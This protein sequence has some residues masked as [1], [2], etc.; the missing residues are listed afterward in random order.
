M[1]SELWDGEW[2]TEA[3]EVL[4]FDLA[5][6]CRDGPAEELQKTE[7]AQPALF[8]A[9]Y[10]AWAGSGLDAPA[11]VAG[12]S[13]GEYT[14]VAA[15]GALTFADALRLVAER[16]RAMAAAG[17]ENP[18]AMAALLGASLEEAAALCAQLEALWVAAC[19]D[20]A[21]R[22]FSWMAAAAAARVHETDLQIMFGVG[23]EH[24]LT[25]RELD[26]LAG[27]RDSRPVRIGNDAWSQRQ[28]DVSRGRGLACGGGGARADVGRGHAV[29]TAQ[30][31]PAGEP[32]PWHRGRRHGRTGARK[33]C[34]E[35]ERPAGQFPARH[36]R[37][38]G[39]RS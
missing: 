4:G 18:G 25:E 10:A 3:G 27:W 39:S 9:A 37:G 20:E 35:G 6:L 28:L 15:S 11:F 26:H 23:G 16:G 19:P 7:H 12:H 14:A 13:L 36:P 38:T 32:C 31:S 34:H 8:V 30:E 24:D 2:F 1:A 33:V 5:A 22:F 17:Q 21:H 29:G